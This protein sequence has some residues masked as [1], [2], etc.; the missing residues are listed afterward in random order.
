M[1]DPQRRLTPAEVDAAGLADWRHAEDTL[2][3]RFRTGSFAKGLELVNRIGAAAEAA[4]HHPD[5]LLTYPAVGVTLSSHDVGGITSRDLDLA[6]T[7]SEQAA[8][9]GARPTPDKA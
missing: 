1:S 2:R 3:A 8:D 6:R 7:I 4:N 9:I 5:V